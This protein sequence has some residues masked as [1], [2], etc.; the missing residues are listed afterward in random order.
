M[1]TQPTL[2]DANADAEATQARPGNGHTALPPQASPRA[3]ADTHADGDVEPMLAGSEAVPHDEIPV[4]T[5]LP[6][7]PVIP[8]HV[9]AARLR[10]PWWARLLG[11]ILEPWIELKLEPQTPQQYVDARPVCYVLEDYGLSQRA[12]PRPRLPRSR[13]A[14]AAAAVAGRSARP[15]ARLRRAVAAQRQQ[16]AAR[17]RPAPAAADQDPFRIAGA[18]ARG[19]PRRSRRSTCSWC[20]CRSS[21]A[22]RRTRTAAGSRCCSR[23]T[24][25]WSAASAA[26]WRSCSTAATRWCASR[27]RSRCAAIVDEGLPPERTVRKLSRVLRTHFH[28]IRAAV[29]GPDLSTRRLLVDQVL[30]VEPV[31]GR[32]RRPGAPRRQR[33]IQ[34]PTD[35]WKKAHA[36]AYEIAADYSHPVV[37]SVELPADHG[38]EPHLPRRA[39]APPRQAQG[40]SRPATKSSTCPAT[41]ATWTT[42]CCRYLLYTRGIVPPHIV[43]GINLN[44]PVIGT[45]LRKGGAFFIRRSIRGNAL[46]SAVFSE[47]VAQLVVGRLLDRVLHRGRAL[48]H[49]PPAAAQGRHGGDDGARVPAPADAAGAVPAGV[50]RLREADGGQQLPRRADRQAEGEGIDLGAAVGHPQGAAQQLRPGGGELRRADSRSTT[51]SAAACAGLG[52][53]RRWP[54]TTSRRGC[55]TPSTR[56]AQRIQ[57]NINRAADVNPIN[58]LALALLSTPKHAMGEADLLAQIALSQDAAG[59]R[60]VL[61]PRHRHPAFAAARSSPT[62]RRST[63]SRAPRIRSATCSASTATTRCC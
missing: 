27:R 20:R 8:P 15:Q 37:R 7:G 55:R 42:C 35:A 4:Q 48:A 52:R 47:Y 51:C 21:S 29:I 61:R 56:L 26:C 40:R 45:L 28:R 6:V 53:R 59:R 43:A 12:D 24:G 31:Q 60:A 62:A 25:P 33:N 36:Y 9:A 23:K 30:A 38:V 3:P 49:R 57:V 17:R 34:A 18:P 14:V 58:L 16:R 11:W 19:A 13:P 2:F 54:R 46:Y 1:P 32:H 41:A 5:E 44:L 63:C 39:G 50:H 22:A 10:R